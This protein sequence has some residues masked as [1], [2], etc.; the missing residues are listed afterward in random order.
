[1]R[2]IRTFFGGGAEY[3][4]RRKKWA[5]FKCE[6]CGKEQHIDVTANNTFDYGKER[7]CPDCGQKGIND[8][9]S[10]LKAEIEKLTADMNRLEIQRKLAVEKLEKLKTANKT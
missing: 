1:M 2:F 8:Y 7:I 6:C 10:N 3:D 5:E 4:P 9:E